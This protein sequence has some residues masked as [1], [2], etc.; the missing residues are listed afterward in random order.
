VYAFS[1]R[2][3]N[4]ENN[5]LE[6]LLSLAVTNTGAVSTRNERQLFS[7]FAEHH[8]AKC[9]NLGVEK[10]PSAVGRAKMRF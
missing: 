4:K 1:R 10:W 3:S 2:K 7:D 6:V 8:G 5:A 9:I